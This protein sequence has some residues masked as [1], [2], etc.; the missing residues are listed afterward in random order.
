MRIESL[1]LQP[2]AFDTILDFFTGGSVGSR[3]SSIV[4]KSLN[5]ADFFSSKGGNEG[6]ESTNSFAL[7]TSLI[8]DSK[9]RSC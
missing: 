2:L 3:S 7:Q 4:S 1:S 5:S 6:K 8:I 9:V